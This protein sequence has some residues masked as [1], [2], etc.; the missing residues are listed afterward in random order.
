MNAA[1]D[2]KRPPRTGSPCQAAPSLSSHPLSPFIITSCSAPHLLH[3]CLASVDQVR[4]F[5]LGFC[6]IS[7]TFTDYRRGRVVRT[8]VFFEEKLHIFSL[9]SFRIKNSILCLLQVTAPAR[10]LLGL[11]LKPYYITE[12]L[13]D[14][15]NHQHL[16]TVP[17]PPGG[18]KLTH[19]RMPLLSGT[20]QLS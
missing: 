12:N 20:K 15:I 19:P 17:S 5:K 9:F 1:G 4:P 18:V 3:A 2:H 13:G 8:A 16:P 6:V 10:E 11:L 7:S 14:E